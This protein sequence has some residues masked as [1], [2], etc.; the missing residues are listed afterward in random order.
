MRDIDF[1]RLQATVTQLT[2]ELADLKKM[3]TNN[4]MVSAQNEGSLAEGLKMTSCTLAALVGVISTKTEV[5]EQ[6]VLDRAK[7]LF[8]DASN[9]GTGTEE[10]RAPVPEENPHE[11]AFIFRAT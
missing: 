4:A 10:I 8:A 6:D 3:V 11:K 1:Y 2:S 5:S 9:A 7:E